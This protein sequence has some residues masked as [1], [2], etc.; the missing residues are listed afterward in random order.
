MRPAQHR[1]GGDRLELDRGVERHHLRIGREGCG[2]RRCQPEN[3]RPGANLVGAGPHD[4]V[5]GAA[6]K[7]PERFGAEGIVKH[8]SVAGGEGLPAD[9]DKPG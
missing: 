2:G 1:F 4:G 5:I 8:D 6:S 7:N 3:D 9:V